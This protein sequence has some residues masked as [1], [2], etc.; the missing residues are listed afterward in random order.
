MSTLS[1]EAS[2]KS[3]RVAAKKQRGVDEAPSRRKFYSSPP[4]TIKPRQTAGP[5]VEGRVTKQE[6]VLTLLSRP[7]GASIEEMMRAAEWQKHSVRGM[8]AGTVKKKVPYPQRSHSSN[9]VG[10]GLTLV[11]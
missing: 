7:E 6:R 1:S 4:A 10:K 5:Q 2:P 9:F 11:N 3:K 8:L